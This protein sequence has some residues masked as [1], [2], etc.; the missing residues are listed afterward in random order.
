M[1]VC[2][3]A[4]WPSLASENPPGGRNTAAWPP[5]RRT[6]DAPLT[7]LAI[8]TSCYDLC[9]SWKQSGYERHCAQLL[10]AP[11]WNITVY[12]QGSSFEKIWKWS[13]LDWLGRKCHGDDE[14]K[15]INGQEGT[16]FLRFRRNLKV[17]EFSWDAGGCVM[18]RGKAVIAQPTWADKWS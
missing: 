4:S 15:L 1:C 2:D 7:E 12:S 6:G 17:F 3:G 8:K 18:S 16:N 13:R 9:C 14:S 11:S 10:R 5:R